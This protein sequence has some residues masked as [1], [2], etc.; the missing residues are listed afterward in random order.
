MEYDA[1]SFARSAN[2]KAMGMWL[3][4]LVILSGAYAIEIVKGLKTVQYFV[5]MEICAWV[6]FI[7]GLVV[8][9]IRGWQSRAYRDIVGLGY[10][11]FYIYIMVTSP[12]TLA[13]AYT[14]PLMSMC[15]IF[16][17]RSFMLRYGA[18]NVAVLIFAIAR[19]FLN[20][21]NTA[22][23]VSNY[24][25]QLGLTVF[26]YIGYIVAIKHMSNSDNAMLDSVKG[27][28]ARVIT[29]VDQVKTASNSVVDGVTVVREL[30]EENKEGASEVVESM[31]GLVAKSQELSA[32]IDSS[33]EM[34]QDIDN[35]VENVAGLIEHIVEV[36]D[37]S[38]SHAKDS[39]KELEK[40]VA[41]TNE[42][43]KLS[44][45]VEVV[46]NEFRNQFNRVKE[47]TGTITKI[48]SQTNLLALNASIEAARAGE[49]GKGFAVVADEIRN[50]SMGTQNSSNGIMEALQLLE[51][52]ADNMTE[53]ITT[54]LALIG[55]TLE[56]MQNVNT[57]VS[58]IAE[59]S[60]ELGGEIEVVDSAVKQVESANK[61]MVE[62][63]KQVRDIMLTMTESVVQSESTTETMLSKYEETA[64]NVVN[65]ESVVGKLVEELGAG[66]FMGM[67]D[68]LPGMSVK[69]TTGDGKQSFKTVVA[70]AGEE[71][72]LVEASE[73]A[74]NYFGE[75][76]A[77]AKYEVR[78]VV[79]N[80]VYVWES[81]PVK[82]GAK[83]AAGFYRLILEGNPK[84]MN[85]RKH[86]R[87]PV[88]N[89]CEITLKSTGLS[90]RGR[91]VNISAG[92]FAFAC[93]AEEFANVTGEALSVAVEEFP[94][95]K[96][97]SLMGTAIRSSND[98]GTYIVG[99]RMPGDSVEIMNYVNKK[100]KVK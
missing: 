93:K 72:V 86:P 78:I 12:G 27:N 44:G 19:N 61:N 60:A 89:S 30:A 9:K 28:L 77:K 96:G 74:S 22:N 42:M 26:C 63:M 66:G 24:E 64:R 92:G 95:L 7:I 40:V 6:P 17:S 57:S 52:T 38:A 8:V 94:L 59:D 4:M 36:A 79:N 84:V 65:I 15:I 37:K 16:K 20:G 73:Q 34:T 83:E 68:I 91:L 29:T 21:M 41:S 10:T 35:Q 47:E 13:F 69:I 82:K 87:L 48:T 97:E 70:S 55:E 56:K 49:A 71:E 51:E 58:M 14:L 80:A 11:V 23:D 81:V 43:A 99:C 2:K 18:I 3:A 45:A 85:R 100:L 1:K 53:S 46:L 25:I 33:M 31:E 75:G 90:F 39:T 98:R 50:L 76:N 32:R 54:I 62:N 5:L 88:T 67:K